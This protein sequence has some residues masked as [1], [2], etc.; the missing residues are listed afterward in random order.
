MIP[1]Q[2]I[3]WSTVLIVAG[4]MCFALTSSPANARRP[5]RWYRMGDDPGQIVAAGPVENSGNGTTY[6]SVGVSGQGNF[7]DLTPHGSPMYV[8]IAGSR[9]VPAA[10]SN[11]WAVQFD[12]VDDYLIG[13]N[14]NIPSESQAAISGGENYAGIS[15]RG[16]QLWAKPVAL[17]T[18]GNAFVIDDAD[19][20][21]FRVTS[22]GFWS[23]ETRNAAQTSTASVA[24][25]TWTHV[26]QVRPNGN[27][28][29]SLAWVNGV[30]VVSQTGDYPSSLTGLV[31][32]A[33]ATTDGVGGTLIPG[34]GTYFAGL[35]DE[36][37][38]F[39]LGGTYGAFSYTADNGYFTDVFLPSKNAFYSYVDATGP[40][41]TPDGHNDKVWV[42][43]DMNFD[44]VKNQ[45]DINA[46][47]AGWR[48]S[49]AASILGTGPKFGDYV[50]LGKGDL[51][52]DGD[53]DI[54]DWGRLRTVFAGV[55]SIVMPS[56][57]QLGLAV[58]EPGTVGLLLIAM[59]AATVWM[60]RGF[61]V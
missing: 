38:M 35:I 32:G 2:R 53:T 33:N 54:A 45:A 44:G 30:A 50:T 22:T 59:I 57:A 21:E 8:N 48:S 49:N 28:G 29:G 56:A 37:D 60:R 31:I 10:T 24:L 14:L 26:A 1:Q 47:I 25:N 7:Q 41:G 11:N 20:H 9:P 39:V 52:L 61:R 6:D 27:A 46:F 19:Q 36:I 16:Y 12:G 43:G 3:V 23:P 58:P 5:D 15:D 42:A 55:G 13:A 40:L 18:T 51:D 17:P 34:A 4:A